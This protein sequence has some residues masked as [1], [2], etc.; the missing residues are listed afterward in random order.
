[1]TSRHDEQRRSWTCIEEDMV[2]RPVSSTNKTN[3]HDIT[4]I[5]LNVAF[6]TIKQTKLWNLVFTHYKNIVHK[7]NYHTIT[8]ERPPKI[9][10]MLNKH[11]ETYKAFHILTH[12]IVSR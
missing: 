2:S 8:A 12:W 3:R 1:M 10:R 9:Q 6:N 11:E 4:E 5:L 7:S